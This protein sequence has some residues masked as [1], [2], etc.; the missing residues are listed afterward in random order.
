MKRIAIEKIIIYILGFMFCFFTSLS[1]GTGSSN[2]KQEFLNNIS[3]IMQ[4]YNYVETEYITGDL[5]YVQNDNSIIL[6]Y[7]TSPKNVQLK[8]VHAE[9]NLNNESNL[10]SI[11]SLLS[12]IYNEN[13]S[14]YDNE[15]QKMIR[16]YTTTGDDQMW[17]NL[18][19]NRQLVLR[20]E[21]TTSTGKD[22]Q[23]DYSIF[24]FTP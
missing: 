4:K 17:D 8:T 1:Q 11:Y 21:K 9:F 6:S 12:E 16:D 15:I 3:S 14:S 20:I 7:R 23:L 13:I 22:Y 2:F 10:N 5:K 24:V 18:N 19:S